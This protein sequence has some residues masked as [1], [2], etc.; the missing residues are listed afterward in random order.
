MNADAHPATP[1]DS[2]PRPEG[3][4]EP[5]EVYEVL[6]GLGGTTTS[7]ED[8]TG[9]EQDA[10]GQF[11][12][13]L[14]LLHL[15]VA[16][17]ALN[18]GALPPDVGPVAS[19]KFWRRCIASVVR[20]VASHDTRSRPLS[21]ARTKLEEARMWLGKELGR[22][23]EA[24]PYPQADDPASPVIELEADTP[25]FAS[26]LLEPASTREEAA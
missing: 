8:L 11:T 6:R 26:V 23:G 22:L 24:T 18:G 13:W 5:A 7:F 19:V 10:W 17:D 16:I 25:P 15:G 9:Q 12:R 4:P 2:T 14:Y 20:M 3:P 1:P 21:L